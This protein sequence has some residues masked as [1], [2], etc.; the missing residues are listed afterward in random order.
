MRVLTFLFDDYV[1]GMLPAGHL[2]EAHKKIANEKK[3]DAFEMEQ[4]P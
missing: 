1:V 2:A 3:D 4:C